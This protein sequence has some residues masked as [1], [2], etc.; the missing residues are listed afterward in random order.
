[1]LMNYKSGKLGVNNI[2]FP[3]LVTFLEGIQFTDST[4]GKYL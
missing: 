4:E 1:M 3:G 2:L